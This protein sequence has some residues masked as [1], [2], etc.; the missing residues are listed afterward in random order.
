MKAPK[1]QDILAWQGAKEQ[2]Y[3]KSKLLHPI[4][5]AWTPYLRS[6]WRLKKLKIPFDIDCMPAVKFTQNLTLPHKNTSFL[7]NSMKLNVQKNSN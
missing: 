5:C 7:I 6:K 3:Q 4:F 2:V 1:K